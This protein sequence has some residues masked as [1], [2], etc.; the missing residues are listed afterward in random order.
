MQLTFDKMVP[1]YAKSTRSRTEY[2]LVNSE[3]VDQCYHISFVTL[4]RVSVSA[5]KHIR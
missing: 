4:D 5:D 3:N 1:T 2:N